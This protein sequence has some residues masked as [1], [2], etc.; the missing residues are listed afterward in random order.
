[1]C[2][3][4]STTHGVSFATVTFIEPVYWSSK[5]YD[6]HKDRVDS[7]VTNIVE[8]TSH[9][10]ARWASAAVARAYLRRTSPRKRWDQRAL[11]LYI[12]RTTS[13][14]LVDVAN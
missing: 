13:P 8:H 6:L 12:V 2:R 5:F 11:D 4:L 14:A 9:R 1:M 7:V 3:A 10:E